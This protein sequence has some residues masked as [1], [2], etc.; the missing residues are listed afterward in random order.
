M[1]IF[2]FICLNKFWVLK[3]TIEMI[4]FGT[5]QLRS[6]FYTKLNVSGSLGVNFDYDR[7]PIIEN[8]GPIFF[9]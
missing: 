3:R 9:I 7:G 4:C 1:N 8:E 6:G 5:M 2:L